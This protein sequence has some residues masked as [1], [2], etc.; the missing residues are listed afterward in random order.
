[1]LIIVMGFFD[2]RV[3]ASDFRG[4]KIQLTAAARGNR[5]IGYLWFSIK[6]TRAPDIFLQKII[7]SD[8]WRVYD[9]AAEVPPQASKITYGLAYLGQ[10]AVLID[11]V[12]LH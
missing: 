6:V 5:G 12:A 4:E 11:D 3:G 10:G 9:I 8:E 2:W 1:M 7:S